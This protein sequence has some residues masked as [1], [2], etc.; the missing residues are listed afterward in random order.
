MRSHFFIAL[1][2]LVMSACAT[3]GNVVDAQENNEQ[4][5]HYS[6]LEGHAS[7]IR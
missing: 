5:E 3:K 6:Q 7:R 4:V 2:A 1:L